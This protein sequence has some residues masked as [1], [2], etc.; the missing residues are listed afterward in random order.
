MTGPSPRMDVQQASPSAGQA[1]ASNASRSDDLYRDLAARNGLQY[2]HDGL[3]PLPAV[4][5]QHAIASGI[6][7]LDPAAG[8]L[9]FA[10]APSAFALKVLNSDALEGREDVVIMPQEG[11][12]AMLREHCRDSI[13]DHVARHLGRLRP[14]QSAESGLSAL[15]WRWSVMFGLSVALSSWLSPT[16]TLL[17]LGL[18]TMPL[19]FGL[20]LLRLAAT[21]DARRPL[22]QAASRLPDDRLP[23]YTV[24][25]PLYREAAVAG[26]LVTA[27]KRLD[28]PPSRLEI[29]FIV[30][31][32]DVETGQALGR[33]DLPAHMSVLTAPAGAPRTK[34][35]ALNTGLMEARGELV[36]VF[37]A[38][39]R[40]DPRQLRLAANVFAGLP[41]DVA[42]LQARLVI[43]NCD[44]SALTRLFA[45]EYAALFDVVNAGLTRTGLPILLGGT[46]NH[47]RSAAL[48]EIGGWDAWNV[49]EDADLSFRFARTGYKIRDLRSDTLE[50]APASYGLWFRQRTRWM[51]GFLQTLVT[52]LRSPL[53]FWG[54]AGGAQAFTLLSLCGG[55]L[56]S[57]LGYPFFV[58]ATVAHL[59]T[60]G[61][62]QPS[63]LAETLLVGLWLTLFA[64]GLVAML[65]PL[66]MG[67]RRR[68]LTD[69]VGWIAFAPIYYLLV[70]AAAWAALIEYGRSPWR[71]NKTEHGLA[72]TSRIQKRLRPSTVSQVS[73]A[74]SPEASTQRRR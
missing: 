45:L 74:T 3:Q 20:V 46:S 4:S 54:E 50:E 21:I 31:H 71:W 33:L 9:R 14:G 2:R 40:P 47:F 35:R 18:L 32:D 16:V 41:V 36:T 19:F 37:D 7:A 8:P 26:Q 11:F 1:G 49:T 15:Q 52:H 59:V 5:F 60:A 30:E 12:R 66:I 38:E 44:D 25:V 64:A 39:D 56:L 43:D 61:W 34:P 23:I 63:T 72:K 57:V 51:K 53:V 22:P 68:G 13:R 17:V 29:K 65:A 48:R 6:A 28:Y 58:L 42:C 27:L 67:A 10:L 62:P 55:A 70:S 69:L 24:L 73:P